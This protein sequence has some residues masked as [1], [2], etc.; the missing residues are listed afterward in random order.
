MLL[1]SIW[2]FHECDGSIAKEICRHL[3]V[4]MVTSRLL[5]QRGINGVEEARNFLHTD[6]DN[7]T[8]PFSMRGMA[9][10]VE[11]IRKAIISGQKVIIYGDYDVDGV[12]SIVILKECLEFLGCQVDYYV[13][14]RFSE[15]YGLNKGAVESLARQGYE[16]LITVDCGISSVEETKLAMSMGMDV[17]IT[18]HHTPPPQQPPALAIINPKN[19][20][21]REI[22]NLAGAGVA[23]KL[24]AALAVENISGER[25]KE[26]LDLVAVAT[27]ADIVPLLD[28]NR[29]LVKYGLRV[30]E[31]TKRPGLRA[32]IRETGLEGKP[33]QSWQV[34]FVL[35]PR[36]NSAGRLESARISI[37]LLTCQDEQEASEK[38]AL[39]SKL[40][41]ER[42]LIEEGI[43]QEA[44][45]QVKSGLTIEEEPI[46]VVE[47]EGWHQGVIGIVASRL[48][49]AF[50][51]PAIVISW[52]GNMGKGSARSIGGFNLYEALN[53]AESFMLEF[54][55]HKMAAGLSISRD[56]LSSF[57]AALKHYAG[58]R[59]ITFERYKRYQADM[60]I[61]EED[62]HQKLMD[63]MEILR[64][65]GEGNP[66]PRFVL[67]ASTISSPAWVGSKRTH[68]KFRTGTNN[69]EA[70]AFNLANMTDY[71]LQSCGQD[72]LFELDV[73][74]F[75]GKK[76]LQLKVKDL[77]AAFV[78]DRPTEEE[79]NSIRLK[80]AIRRA[81]E[82][83]RE[84]RPV[85]FVYPAYRSLVKHQAVLEYFFNK[86][87]VRPI[88]GH[89]NL[90]GK[91]LAQKQLAQGAGMVFLI[92]RSFLQYFQN[93]FS[94][95][96]N[97]RF[98]VRMWPIA[99]QDEDLLNLGNCDIET[100]ER[101]DKFSL[102]RSREIADRG[103]VVVYA[104][105]SKTV[106]HLNNHHPGINI[107]SGLMDMRQRRAVRK[108]YMGNAK[109]VLLSDGT[110]T[111]GW[112]HISEI[113]EI[114]LADS[115]LGWYEL[116][117]VTDYLSSS[118]GLRIGV[119]FE[120]TSL[121]YNRDFL[122]RLYPNI[123]TV[124]EF[125]SYYIKYTPGSSR[126][127]VDELVSNIGIHLNKKY[128]RLEILS[129]L[130]ILADLG[131]CRFEKSGSIIAINFVNAEN[132]ATN[133]CNTPYYLEGLAEKQVL[134]EWE[135]KL[136]NSLVW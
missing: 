6:L 22:V 54:G 3:G 129:A 43:Y 13:P 136:N 45:A 71:P 97:L 95:P 90:E 20:M 135:M 19:D 106:N 48:T 80:R 65:F 107:E 52:E 131:L 125:L 110:H 127:K 10:A 56:Q 92:T 37:E 123:D 132:S 66:V 133:I 46:L 1:N 50:N 4:S 77:K 64:P 126:V 87:N 115:P 93:S 8:D 35:G 55:G 23:F 121:E 88:H 5:V 108:L 36:I 113:D 124:Q 134:T 111:A 98:M 99:G 17:I 74:D 12:C 103:R 117:S 70:I 96:A 68:L 100:I 130:R 76:N 51:R 57:K 40:N 29:I 104:N 105:L 53:Q 39:L 61:E 30:L 62:I 116:A 75:R 119:T 101:M 67:R 47:G 32:L 15:G 112:P 128:S 2:E 44:L 122:N 27:V 9:P 31:N 120:K 84:K 16:L 85:L 14:N 82:E 59:L 89:L 83:I 34:G 41:N 114:I 60:E 18:D 24:A 26:W 102:Y 49:E 42:R 7:L 79:N 69:I 21:F 73:N 72:L 118:E 86:H 28:E 94:L 91:L 33:I 109:G 58:E 78:P 38:A 11:R 63:E 25:V 81:V